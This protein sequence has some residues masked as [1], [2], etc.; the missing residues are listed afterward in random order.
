MPLVSI[1]KVSISITLDGE[2]PPLGQVTPLIQCSPRVMEMSTGQYEFQL[3]I[4]EKV[5]PDV[6]FHA[7][8]P[9]VWFEYPQ[10]EAASAV[11]VEA[12]GRSCWFHWQNAGKK[13]AGRFLFLVRLLRKKQIYFSQDP[14]IY[15]KDDGQPTGGERRSRAAKPG[16][17]RRVSNQG[18]ANQRAPKPPRR[19][20]PALSSAEARSPTRA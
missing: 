18:R 11:V 17:A 8:E 16:R 13:D 10:P 9:L 1:Q 19:A 15:N 2:L 14:T 6:R 3:R 7:T 12:G 4:D 20:R 5:D